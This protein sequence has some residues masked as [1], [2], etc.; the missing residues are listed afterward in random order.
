[1]SQRVLL[2]GWGRT[3]PSAATVVR[4]R[5]ERDVRA[6]MVQ[7]GP[8]GLIARGLGR[9]YGDPAQNAGGTVLDLTGAGEGIELDEAAGVVTAGAGVSFDRLMRVLVP[10][11]W[12][13]P[14]V[15]GT[16]HVTVG[17]AVAND[18]H[19]KNHHVDGSFGQHVVD[20]RLALPDGSVRTIGPDRDGELYAAT[21]GGVGLTGIITSCRFRVRRI[22]TSRMLVDTERASDLD[23]VMARM[24]EGD[25]R[26]QYSVAWIDLMATGRHLGRSVLTRGDHAPLEALGGMSAGDALAFDPKV[27]VRAPAATPGHLLNRYSIRAFNEAWYRKAPKLRRDELQPLDTF[28]HPLDRVDDWNQLYRSPGFLQHQLVVPFGAER[29]LRAVVER[30][31]Q[32]GATSFLAVLKRFGPG[33]GAPL[34]FPM[35]GLDADDGRARPPGR[36]GRPARRG[37]PHR[38][39]TP[40]AA[41]TWPRTAAWIRRCCPRCTRIWPRGRRCGP[42]STRTASSSP[43]SAAGSGCASPGGGRGVEGRPRRAAVGARARRHERHRPGHHPPAGAAAVPHRRARR[44]PARAARRVRRRAAVDGRHHRRDHRL[45]RQPARASTPS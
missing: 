21:T 2:T 26:Y 6:A 22:E 3:A 4:P 14:V 45:R 5:D 39:W 34:S 9:S 33:T 28:F 7:A 23:D 30:I 11:G 1:M 44:P 29:E 8:R 25:H 42:R 41:S 17:G 32:A 16:R 20:L 13:L 37:G 31:S 15:P 36:P 38:S 43:T 35:A 40:V 10:R 12:F 18:I 24:A 27:W 19:G